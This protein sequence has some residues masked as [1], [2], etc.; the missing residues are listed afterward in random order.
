MSLSR[1]EV[2]IENHIWANLLPV[3]PYTYVCGFCGDKVSSDKGYPAIQAEYHELVR[4]QSPSVLP[5]PYATIRICP[6]CTGPTFF[7]PSSKRFPANAPGEAVPDIPTDLAALYA[8][9]RSSA[10]AGAYTGAVL[11]CRKM[12]MNI[13]VQEEAKPNE[14]FVSYIDHLASKGF[15]PPNGRGW[16]DYIRKRGNEATHEIALMKEEDAIALITFVE[17]LLRF[18]YEFPKMVPSTPS[19]ST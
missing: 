12:L 11:L 16:V 14:T 10:A 6:S 9:A 2:S 17:M 8:E 5:P 7:S 15:I 1:Q 13:A 4:T 3:P 18:T 19:P